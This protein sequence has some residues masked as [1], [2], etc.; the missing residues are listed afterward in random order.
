QHRAPDHPTSNIEHRTSDTERRTQDI[1]ASLRIVICSNP[2][3]EATLAAREIL[4]FVRAGGRFRDT[5]VLV[6]NLED[7]HDSLER[8]FRRYQLPFFMDRREPIAHHPLAELTRNALRTVT[9]GWL[10]IGRA[11]V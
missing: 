5:A 1:T 7:Y 11:H 6:R 3:A 2:E 4:R 8:V 10:Q 9:L